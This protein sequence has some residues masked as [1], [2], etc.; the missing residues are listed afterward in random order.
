MSKDE[1]YNGWRNYETWCVAL[2]LDNE[3]GSWQYWNEQAQEVYDDAEPKYDWESKEDVAKRELADRLKS[4][5]EE[6]K[7]TE[8]SGVYADLLTAA[9]GSVDWYEI[10]EHYIDEVDKV[11]EEAS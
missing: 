9:L 4:D 2:W 8:P 11:E 6:N 5:H 7:P 10:A 3:Q 1:T